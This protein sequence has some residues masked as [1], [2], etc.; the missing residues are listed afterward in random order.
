MN[1]ELTCLLLQGFVATLVVYMTY[2]ITHEMPK[3]EDDISNNQYERY[4]AKK[5]NELAKIDELADKV[6]RYD[7]DNLIELFGDYVEI[8]NKALGFGSYD[9]AKRAKDELVGVWRTM[10]KLGIMIFVNGTTALEEFENGML[11]YIYNSKFV[12]LKGFL[13]EKENKK[14]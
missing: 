5:I 8:Y 4:R 7:F 11:T 13:N 3:K 2:Y 14:K 10:D 9:S 1:F 6:D 12:S